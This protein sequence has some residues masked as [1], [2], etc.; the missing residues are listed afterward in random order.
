MQTSGITKLSVT[1]SRRA[2]TPLSHKTVAT[3]YYNCVSN[4]T[5]NNTVT[6]PN[7]L[8]VSIENTVFILSV[9]LI[10]PFILYSRICLLNQGVTTKQLRDILISSSLFTQQC[11][12]SEQYFSLQLVS[13]IPDAYQHFKTPES[14]YFFFRIAKLHFCKQVIYRHFT[15]HRPDGSSQ[16]FITKN[17]FLRT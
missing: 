4:L 13:S 5:N 11:V 14:K 10:D 12:C 7:K 1:R 15:L 3:I 8:F 6:R 9:I 2:V 17:I 16:S